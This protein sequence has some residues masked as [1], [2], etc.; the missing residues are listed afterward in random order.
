MGSLH[1]SF[2][3]CNKAS[4]K[5]IRFASRNAL[6]HAQTRPGRLARWC[7]NW[8]KL[9]PKHSIVSS[10]SD[11][12]VCSMN[13][14]FDKAQLGHQG[15]DKSIWRLLI[16]IGLEVDNWSILKDLYKIFKVSR[17]VLIVSLMMI[18]N[19]SCLVFFSLRTHFSFFSSVFYFFWTPATFVLFFS[20]TFFC[21]FPPPS[22]PDY[23]LLCGL[24]FLFVTISSSCSS[25]YILLFVFY[26]CTFDSPCRLPVFSY[27]LQYVFNPA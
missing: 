12:A 6:M 24:P 23:L 8:S 1:C 26:S 19:I 22:Y 25:W 14:N 21:S 7:F 20:H 4:I 2:Y 13:A 18:L 3:F 15:Q 9:V 17:S 27:L 10:Q 16:Q 11:F 5:C